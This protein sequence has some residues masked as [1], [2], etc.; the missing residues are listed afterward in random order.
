MA[1]FNQP[2][3]SGG[4]PSMN[5][6]A[7]SAWD[8]DDDFTSYVNDAAGDAVWV[9]NGG[10]SI[11]VSAAND[12]IDWIVTPLADYCYRD[13][14]SVDDTAF[15]V[16]QKISPTTVGTSLGLF[17][18]NM[19]DTLG[20]SQTADDHIAIQWY[21]G[22]NTTILMGDAAKRVD[23]STTNDSFGLS[24]AVDD[25]WTEMIRTSAT[26]CTGEIFSDAFSTTTH[27]AGSLTISS[28]IDGLRY[29]KLTGYTSG[30][31]DGTYELFQFADGVTTAP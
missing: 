24:P 22:G 15:V 4:F 28:S 8:V 30:A 31:M 14:T 20:S 12:R 2:F 27:T 9:P 26:T 18:T 11:S 17:Y 7:V 21:D 5:R 16:R 13:L 29:Y 19:S 23:Q 6:A 1:I 3:L 10:E 25:Y